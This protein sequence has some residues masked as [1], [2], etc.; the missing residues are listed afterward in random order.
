M[1]TDKRTARRKPPPDPKGSGPTPGC[2]VAM[3]LSAVQLVR[4]DALIPSLSTP[5]FTASRSDVLRALVETGLPILEN[6]E[7]GSIR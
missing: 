5:W 2:H 3:R 6:A 7:K 1:T 4:V